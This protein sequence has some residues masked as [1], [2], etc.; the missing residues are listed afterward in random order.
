VAITQQQQH[1]RLSPQSKSI[2]SMAWHGCH[3]TKQQG[4][5]IKGMLWQLLLRPLINSFNQEPWM[6]R[7][8][9]RF[10]FL[11]EFPESIII[12]SHSSSSFPF[13][14]LLLREK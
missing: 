12:H 10:G 9:A 4:R 7:G 2:A 8:N 11:S 3:T 6:E 5:G 1:F 14:S 13:L